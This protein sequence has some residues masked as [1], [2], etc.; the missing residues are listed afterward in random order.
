MTIENFKV[1][2]IIDEKMMFYTYSNMDSA[3]LKKGDIVKPG[4]LIGFAANEFGGVKPTLELW[5]NDN[6]KTVML[7]KEN[8]TARKD[9]KLTDH[10]IDAPTPVRI[11]MK[12]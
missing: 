11:Q 12:F 8:F 9:N 2:I 5:V 4:Q 6:G 10:S 7:T 3:I 1:V